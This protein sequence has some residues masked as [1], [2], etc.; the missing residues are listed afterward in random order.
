MLHPSVRIASTLLGECVQVAVTNGVSYTPFTGTSSRLAAGVS[1]NI[2]RT[3]V[4]DPDRCRVVGATHFD[5]TGAG[6]N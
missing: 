5:V 1:D 6:Y 2:S 4:R 3:S